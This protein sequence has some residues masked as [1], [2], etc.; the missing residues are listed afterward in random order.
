MLI[1][2]EGFDLPGRGFQPRPEFP[3]GHH[4]IHVAIQAREEPQDLSGLVAADAESVLW[5]LICDVVSPPPQADLSVGEI[6]GRQ[7]K[8]FVKISWGVVS[9][10][11]DFRMFRRGQDL[12]GCRSSPD[13]L[14]LTCMAGF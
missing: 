4:N 7:G 5:E 11:G 14:A 6:H 1:R 3:E 8:T 2:I 9:E 10:V 12:V 13:V